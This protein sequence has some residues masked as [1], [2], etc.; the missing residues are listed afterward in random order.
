MGLGMW[1]RNNWGLWGDSRLADWF[2]EKGIDHPDD[3][4]TIILK[5]FWRRLN[6]RPI[7]LSEQIRTHRAYWDDHEPILLD[8]G[9]DIDNQIKDSRRGVV[10]T[11]SSPT[12]PFKWSSPADADQPGLIT[13]RSAPVP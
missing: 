1:M 5:S 13:P 3:M 7:A 9:K 8:R 6:D 12:R 11:F 10:P 4:S 2:A